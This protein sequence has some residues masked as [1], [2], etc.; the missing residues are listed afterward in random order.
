MKAFVGCAHHDPGS[1]VRNAVHHRR[2]ARAAFSEADEVA[3]R[4]LASAAATAIDN[5]QLFERVQMSARWTEASREI[6]AAL[7]GGS[8]TGRSGHAAHC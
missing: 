6:T 4:A 3:V 1:G 2:R 5:A 7:L 8:R